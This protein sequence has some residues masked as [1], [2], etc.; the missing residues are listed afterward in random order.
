MNENALA[1]YDNAR[2]DLIK[3]TIAKGATN[4]ELDMF[5]TQCQRTGLDPFARQL[6]CMERWAYNKQTRQSE[7]KMETQVSIDGFRLIAERTNKYEGQIGPLWCGLDGQWV[8][9][10]LKD[11][12]P[13]AAKVG[14]YKAGCREPFWGVAR[15]TEYVQT[16]QDGQPNSMWLKMPANQLAKCA[17]SLALRKAFPQDLSGLYTSDEMGQTTISTI[18][19]VTG[20]VIEG[21]YT[22]N[23]PATNGHTNGNGKKLLPII[24]PDQVRLS[25]RGD[26]EMHIAPGDKPAPSFNDLG[27]DDSPVAV[28]VDKVTF[29]RGKVQSNPRHTVATVCNAATMTG[30]YKAESHA[31]NAALGISADLEKGAKLT[32]E[33]ALKLFDKL[34]ERKQQPLIAMPETSTDAGYQG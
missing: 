31:L 12:P 28:D 29:Y 7:R 32:P 6:Y 1:V 21:S 11:G 18:D 22:P 15:F 27:N 25:S 24:Q 3:R 4:D 8:D 23:Q 30:A 13:A 26:Y 9:V 10:W 20:E 16:K 2:I 5:I 34:V 17:E 14:V 19:T 33:D